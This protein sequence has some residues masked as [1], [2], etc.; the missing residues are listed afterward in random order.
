MILDLLSLTTPLTKE[1]L[2]I[3]LATSKESVSAVLLVVRKGK[4]Y[5]VHYVSRTLHDAKRNYAPLEKMALVL[6]YISRRLRMYF[7]AHPITVITD[8]PTK[9]I[10]SKA[11]TSGR[12]AQYSVKL[13]AYNIT[14]E[15]CTAIKGQ[16]LA[17]F[18]NEVM[19][20]SKAIVQPQTQYTI[21]H[22]KDCKEEWVLN[23]DGASSFKGF[24][25]GLVLI[26]PTKTEYTYALRLN[27]ESTNNQAEYE[28]LLA[29]LR[30]AKKVGVQSLSVNVDSMLVASQIN[31]NYE[32]CKENMNRYLSKAK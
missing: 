23:T 18:V 3:Y 29:G 26:S 7:D 32:A 25:A 1:T 16:I 27:F 30:I 8:Q 24:S 28:A 5:P 10:L 11:D 13:G 2:F 9:Q 31:G 4:Q 22:Q 21:D 14:Y 15:P 6:R 12:L 17:D 20:G 19:V